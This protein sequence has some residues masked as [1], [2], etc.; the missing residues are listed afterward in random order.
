MAIPTVASVGTIVSVAA[1]GPLTV[2]PGATHTAND[3][4]IVLVETQAGNP[5]LS[6]AA[7]FAEL[8]AVS[9][10]TTGA[11]IMGVFWRRWNGTDGSPAIGQATNHII[12][13]MISISGVKTSGDP[14][15]TTATGTTD[16]SADTSVSIAGGT[17]TVADC[18]I[19]AMLTQDLP[20]ANTATEFS[21]WANID[22]GSVTE[23]MDDT[24]N[25]GNGGAIGMATGTKAVAGAFGA[26]TATAVTSA[27]RVCAMVAL[28]GA[29]AAAKPPRVTVVNFAVT[30]ASTY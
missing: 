4:D 22:L 9:P 18:L 23:Q 1:T 27:V 20:D 19:L 14:W 2:A 12:A 3:I 6:T 11:T 25:P 13:R 16:S 5:T 15:N 7:G 24:R 8:T 30:R 21:G 10:Q 17:T 26:T 29:S 28:E